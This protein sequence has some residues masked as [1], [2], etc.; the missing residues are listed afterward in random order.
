MM[1]NTGTTTT[2]TQGRASQGVTIPTWMIPTLLT[3]AVFFMGVY[4]KSTAAEE[5]KTMLGNHEVEATERFNDLE[6]LAQAHELQLRLNAQRL[7]IIEEVAKDAQDNAG[8]NYRLL[9]R[10][11]DKLE[12]QTPSND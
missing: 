3:G 2:S 4:V 7:I 5:A 11:A 6:K 8:R 12:I 10:I 9:N 1:G